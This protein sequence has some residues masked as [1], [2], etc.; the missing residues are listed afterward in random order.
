MTTRMA[1]T[2]QL[3][4]RVWGAL[5]LVPFLI[6]AGVPSSSDPIVDAVKNGDVDAVRHLIES[7]A[8]VNAAEGDGMTP[9]HWA[10]GRGDVEVARLLLEAGADVSAG[11]RIGTYTPLH[12]A[13]E[14]GHTAVSKLL[15]DA[16][17]D[18]AATTANGW[19]TPLHLAAAA[20]EGEDIVAA[21]IEAGA[22]VNEKEKAA[23]QTPLIF[24]ASY[25]RT[26]SV[27][28]LLAAGADP[29]ATTRVVDALDQLREDLSAAAALSE[30]LDA[31]ES[32]G[33]TQVQAAIRE[34]RASLS[35]PEPELV[36]TVFERPTALIGPGSERGASGI[37]AREFLVRRTGGMTALLHVARE[38]HI[39]AAMAL[40]DGGA[41]V[42]QVSAADAASPLVIAA[43]NGRF[44]LM[45]RLLERGADP[46]LA[47]STDGVTPLFAV[48]QT[49][50]P[51]VSDYPNRLAHLQQKA[52]HLDVMEAL[53]QAGADPNVRLKTHIW[54]WEHGG[55]IGVDLTSATPLWRAAIAQ[56]VE[57]MRVLATY[58][59]DPE[60][61]TT[62]APEL[63]RHGR[64]PDGRGQDDSGLPPVPEGEPDVFPIHA[65]AGGG[66]LGQGSFKMRGVPDGF[67]AAVKFL[68]DDLGVEV[69][70]VDSWGYRPLHYAA[71]RG[72]NEM[73]RYLVSKGAD[74]TALSRLGQ[75]AA[76]MTRGGKVGVWA[77][78]KY[79]DTQELLVSLGSPLVC[80]HTFIREG[81]YFC[82]VAG[83]TSFEDRYGF[84]K[85]PLTERS[86]DELYT[87]VRLLEEIYDY[88]RR[89]DSDSPPAEGNTSA[90]Q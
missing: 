18:I 16:G 42:N 53:L 31:V 59:A 32:P 6:S 58:G 73:V 24:A 28:R 48:L 23:G 77:R 38:G 69:N 52:H 19:A 54:Y 7:G 63:I 89:V 82:P 78:N 60:I 44:D 62:V 57:A 1:K 21:L 39:D 3:G 67:L 22:D 83:T 34:Q 13:V 2:H 75:S 25:G 79:P 26:E 37:G 10:A 35:D 68:V 36:S 87:S 15:I 20:E 50:W 11:T 43:L 40:L 8:D 12:L 4:A 33:P 27:K 46:T 85:E 45:L 9:L 61:P 70:A 41:D 66:W 88:A 17:A 71:V 14:R 49:R 56:D 65:A 51:T 80:E 55:D 29:A 84:S 86:P 72:D 47:T 90:G 64:T 30:K 76:D 74:V 5:F 81:G